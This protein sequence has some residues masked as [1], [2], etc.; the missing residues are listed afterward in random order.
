MVALYTLNE[1]RSIMTAFLVLRAQAGDA[2]LPFGV[3][4]RVLAA[5]VGTL[6]AKR[7]PTWDYSSKESRLNEVGL[8]V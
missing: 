2:L 5:L 1:L 4:L 7:R 8:Q 3:L 6:L